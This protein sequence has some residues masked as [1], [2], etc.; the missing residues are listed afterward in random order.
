MNKTSSSPPRKR[1]SPNIK[2]ESSKP[3]LHPPPPNL[4]AFDPLTLSMIE[5]QRLTAAYASLFAGVS[6]AN[7]F[8]PGNVDPSTFRN[9]TN[10]SSST[11]FPTLDP[12]AMT[13]ALMQRE[14]FL[15]SLRQQQEL[16]EHERSLTKSISKSFLTKSEQISPKNSN[17]ETPRISPKVTTSPGSHSSTSSSSSSSKKIKHVKREHPSP[18]TNE[19]LDIKPKEESNVESTA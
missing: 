3:S 4:G 2:S 17:E 16:I 8:F 12:S 13:T 7:N 18:S 9:H 6:Q 14:H 11:L 19:N 15:N 5:R 10:S 1:N